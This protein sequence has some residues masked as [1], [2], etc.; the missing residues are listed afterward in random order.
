MV[1]RTGA[2]KIIIITPAPTVAVMVFTKTH[3]I[4]HEMGNGTLLEAGREQM[5]PR[6]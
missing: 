6:T 4:G 5:R 3:G 1:D 2:P